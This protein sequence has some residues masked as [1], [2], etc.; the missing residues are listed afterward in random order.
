FDATQGDAAFWSQTLVTQSSNQI[1]NELDLVYRRGNT[2]SVVG[3]LDLRNGSIQADYVQG[4]NCV[5]FE[6]LFSNSTARRLRKDV[7]ESMEAERLQGRI[8]QLLVFDQPRTGV[9]VNCSPTNAA[10]VLPNQ[11]GEHFATRDLGAFAQASYKPIPS[12][13]L[14]AGLRMD[15]GE[16]TQG[17]SFGTVFTP[18]LGVVHS[19]RGFV[20]KAIY[21]DAF[22]NPSNFERFATLPGILDRPDLAL[23]PE[24]ARHLAVSAG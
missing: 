11:G 13:K 20:T 15:N 2:L 24:R 10:P 8:L 6:T 21:S 16:V 18:R 19:Y 14:V 3:G 4:T 17:S 7:L 22:K 23:L 12:I 5:P 1:R 9:W